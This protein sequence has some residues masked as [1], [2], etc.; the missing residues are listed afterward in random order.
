[1]GQSMTAYRIKD[2]S[3]YETHETRKIK[4]L[5]WVPI[6]NKHD[7]L[8]F[9]RIAM[10]PDACEIFTAWI[11]ILQVASKG[12]QEQR[13]LLE[14]DGVPLTPDDLGMMTGYG[15][16]IFEKAYKV[17]SDVSIGWLEVY[18]ES[19]DMP[20]DHPDVPGF[21]PI[22]GRKEGR[23]EQKEQK[24]ILLPPADA[25]WGKEYMQVAEALNGRR[26]GWTYQDFVA[27]FSGSHRGMPPE[28]IVDELCARVRTETQNR[29]EQYGVT[30][31]L[32]YMLRDIAANFRKAEIV[33]GPAKPRGFGK[34]RL[35]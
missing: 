10:R 26:E 14:R 9:K 2:W 27:L 8:S 33:R 31:C 4:S 29:W 23:K 6:P 5:S 15:S 11:L 19:P 22:E 20:G 34:T 30:R 32:D 1:M 13:G 18:N 17:L 35:S 25:K 24:E 12:D 21:R 3:R 7:G 28:E 16:G